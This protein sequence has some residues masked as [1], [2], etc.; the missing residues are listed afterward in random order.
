MATNKTPDYTA[1]SD[2]ELYDSLDAVTQRCEAERLHDA[3]QGDANE[4]RLYQ[5]EL[6]MQNRELSTAAAVLEESRSHYAE[7]YDYAPVGYVT[8]DRTGTILDINLT[9]ASMFGRERRQLVGR[10]LSLYLAQGNAQE[11]LS[12]LRKIPDVVQSDRSAQLEVQTRDQGYGTRDL[13]FLGVTR[14]LPGAEFPER[15]LA[16]Y[17]ITDEK[18]HQ[19]N[20]RLHSLIMENMREGVLLLR[21]SDGVIIETNPACDRMH[22]YAAGE[23]K[24][25][26][27]IALDSCKVQAGKTMLDRL[28]PSTS[29]LPTEW[30]EEYQRRDGSRFWCEA[31]AYSFAHKKYG[32]VWLIVQRD[33]TERHRVQQ[34]AR[35]RQ[36]ALA[37]VTRINTVGELAA[38]LAH[39]LTQ[40][41][42]TVEHVNHAAIAL[43]QQSSVPPQQQQEVL[44]LLRTTERQLQR[45]SEIIFH[46]RKFIR[47]GELETRSVTVTEL[48]DA[49]LAL[50]H[51]LLRDHS[52]STEQKNNSPQL[53]VEVEPVQV[54]QVLVNLISNSV[55]A[56][57]KANSP[58]R[59]IDIGVELQGTEVIV[60]IRDSGPGLPPGINE[61]LFDVLQTDKEDGVGMGLAI[62][63][64]L[65]QGH[66]GRLWAGEQTS[67][68]ACFCFT[69]P[70]AAREGDA[71]E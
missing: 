70:V 57:K 61:Q 19:E 6:E 26:S 33:V 18:L 55:Q 27:L 45:A 32:D 5:I 69:L 35:E 62:S 42:M 28:Q 39:E 1:M 49:S 7:L 67:G 23:L 48:I 3:G 31:S 65:I 47:H 12:F 43:L 52:V 16:I 44:E 58:Q 22:G 11:L 68:G 36:A 60:S 64:S 9:A 21:Q 17:D 56:M 15:R 38:S 63:R 2:G 10:P 41:L 30:E 66:G 46:M 29:V 53:R 25:Q 37:H 71:D 13:R 51:P 40:P 4:V 8:V 50:T 14:T 34:Q 54:E 20:L 59:H 24:G